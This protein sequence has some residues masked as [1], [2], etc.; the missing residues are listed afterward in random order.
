MAKN[1][2]EMTHLVGIM[3]P[4]SKGDWR[5]RGGLLLLTCCPVFTHP[6]V[7]SVLGA[8]LALVLLL[9]ADLAGLVAVAPFLVS[10][11]RETLLDSGG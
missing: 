10:V 5:T 11:W 3:G 9:L 8:D 2:K 6:A 4:F 7:E 1:Q